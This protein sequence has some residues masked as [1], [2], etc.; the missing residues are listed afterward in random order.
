MGVDD[1]IWR[2]RVN[3]PDKDGRCRIGVAGGISRF[4]PE[5]V[6]ALTQ[7]AVTLWA[8]ADGIGSTV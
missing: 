5:R 8:A 7:T 6:T 4:H 2:N 1:R 3:G